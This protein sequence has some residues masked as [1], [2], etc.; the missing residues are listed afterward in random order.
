PLS[1]ATGQ[2]PPAFAGTGLKSP[3]AAL[4]EFQRLCAAGCDAQLLVGGVR[5]TDPQIVGDRT[6][7]QQ[8]LLK[9]HSDIPP[10]RRQLEAADVHAVDL[11]KARLRIERS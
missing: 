4:D 6:I 9:Y 11:D 8:G 3:F 10:Q 7:K 1:L 2:H 5:F